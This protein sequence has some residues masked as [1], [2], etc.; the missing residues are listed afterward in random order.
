MA[1]DG[2]HIT[3]FWFLWAGRNSL[4]DV[5]QS[6]IHVCKNC[7]LFA[8]FSYFETISIHK[9]KIFID[10][11]TFIDWRDFMICTSFHNFTFHISMYEKAKNSKYNNLTPNY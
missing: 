3:L 2:E 6:V 9:K 7:S 10:Y 11:L 5:R 4:T 1:V 8:R